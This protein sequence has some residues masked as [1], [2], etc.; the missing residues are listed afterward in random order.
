MFFRV[1][2]GHGNLGL[3]KREVDGQTLL[4]VSYDVYGIKKWD[5]LSYRG[6]GSYNTD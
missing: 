2:L 1:L 5:T 4:A 3:T 6:F